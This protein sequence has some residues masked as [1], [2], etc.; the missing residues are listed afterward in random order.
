LGRF[1]YTANARQMRI[2]APW[3]ATL[4]AGESSARRARFTCFYSHCDNVVFPA[5]V[6]TLPGADNRHVAGAAHIDMISRS[7][8]FDAVVNALQ[9]R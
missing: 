5:S 2:G 6:A 8:V 1:G 9:T 7:E 4:A 3:L